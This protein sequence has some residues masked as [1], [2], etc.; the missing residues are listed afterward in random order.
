MKF[1]KR[2]LAASGLLTSALL[3]P[4][5]LAASASQN[6]S[7]CD[8]TMEIRDALLGIRNADKPSTKLLQSKLLRPTE[9]DSLFAYK[10]PEEP[11]HCDQ[12]FCV[13]YVAITEH[14]PDQADGDASGVA[15]I[16]EQVLTTLNEA[17]A[18]LNSRGHSYHGVNDGNL[19]GDSRLDV[20]VAQ[21]QGYKGLAVPEELKV[22][23][24]ARMS[25]YLVLDLDLLSTPLSKLARGVIAHELKH[26]YDVATF[27]A[28]PRWLF[29]ST[30]TWIENEM[31][32]DSPG[33]AD[34]FPC[35]F[36]FPE[37]SLDSTRSDAYPPSAK[38][39]HS[40]VFRST[41]IY[42]SATFWF[43]AGARFGDGLQ[44]EVWDRT[45]KDCG[46]FPELED[47]R[48]LRACVTKSID[49]LFSDRGTDLATVYSEF[50]KDMYQPRASS[51]LKQVESDEELLAWPEQAYARQTST[52]PASGKIFL[53]HLSSRYFEFLPDSDSH[54]SLILEFSTEHPEL[55]KLQA[56]RISDSASESWRDIS[57][58]AS[59]RASFRADD[60]GDETQKVVV[61]VSNIATL[62]D[63][64]DVDN[65]PFKYVAELGDDGKGDWV[66][67]ANKGTPGGS[68]GNQG[69]NLSKSGRENPLA[70][71]LGFLMAGLL[72]RYRRGRQHAT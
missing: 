6:P 50:S 67:K 55:L 42:G 23:T 59:G 15:D 57:L 32:D 47:S 9:S 28:A 66:D 68:S 60:F 26:T 52:Y 14:A 64:T 72:F 13:H 38:D 63:G 19:G 36:Q 24:P 54:S 31:V 8:R 37:L 29:E 70:F 1:P 30:A 43:Y 46:A 56:L 71:G 62:D 69:C 44:G 4:P 7:A 34:F 12:H 2:L 51:L 11:P 25:S 10:V 35:W 53:K 41:H 49:E 22:K 17:R 40:C 27:A 5:S 20:Y 33:Y 58:S 61:L 3:A 21:L 18:L 65:V 48:E 45:G 39:K 16:V